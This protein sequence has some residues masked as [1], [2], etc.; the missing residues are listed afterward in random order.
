MVIRVTFQVFLGIVAFI[1]ITY[2]II[3]RQNF[4]LTFGIPFVT[5]NNKNH[6]TISPE[7]LFNRWKGR[8]QSGVDN[9]IK[10]ATVKQN[11]SILQ[12][13]RFRKVPI[14]NNV[15]FQYPIT[16]PAC[17]NEHN[18]FMVIVSAPSYFEK[19]QI[20]RDTWIQHIDFPANIAFVI[21]M[22]PD[23]AIQKEIEQ[24]SS[25]HGDIIQVDMVDGYWNLTLKDVAV[26]NWLNINCPRIPFVFK[27]DDDVYVNVHNL[28]AILKALPQNEASIYGTKNLNHLFVQR[29]YG[30]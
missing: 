23:T 27:C 28:G 9:Y 15:L 30:T 7:K 10:Y 2:F 18:V 3:Y 5:D 8:P 4:E 25:N 29:E 21:G 11:K 14:V 1:W 24:E 19:R 13:Y 20:I 16:V 12:P 6:E 26:L 22:T 17:T